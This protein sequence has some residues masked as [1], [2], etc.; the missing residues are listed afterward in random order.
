M[1]AGSKTKVLELTTDVLS[2]HHYKDSILKNALS[3]W[4]WSKYNLVK[5]RGSWIMH[6]IS[7]ALNFSDQFGHELQFFF[8]KLL[9]GPL[10]CHL[11]TCDSITLK[12]VHKIT[13]VIMTADY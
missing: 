10:S 3:S 4:N 7:N 1:L 9:R 12:C 2:D 8:P 5:Q 13:S 6:Q 11:M